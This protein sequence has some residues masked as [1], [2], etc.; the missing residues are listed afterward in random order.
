MNL[1]N[2]DSQA[3]VQNFWSY[4]GPFYDGITP[5]QK[6]TIEKFW[7]ALA[8]GVQS[9]AI[10]SLEAY[11]SSNLNFT[12]GYIEDRFINLKIDRREC[13][14]IPHSP[15]V[16]EILHNDTLTDTYREIFITGV[17]I[18]DGVEVQTTP[19][20]AAIVYTSDPYQ[21]SWELLPGIV[22]Y[23]VYTK[24]SDNSSITYS[25]NGD[26]NVIDNFDSLV[27]VTG[28]IYP[29]KNS[30]ILKY[31]YNLGND[32][33]FITIPTLVTKYSGLTLV[34]GVDYDIVNLKELHINFGIELYDEYYANAIIKVAPVLKSLYLQ[35]FGEERHYVEIFKQSFYSSYVAAD[36]DIEI[37]L[38]NLVHLAKLVHAIILTLLKGCSL[39][40]LEYVVNLFYNVPFAYEAGK[41]ESIDEYDVNYNIINI[42]NILYKIP[43]TLVFAYNV[44]DNVDKYN[45]LCSNTIIADDYI[46]NLNLLTSNTNEDTLH[47]TVVLTI[48]EEITGLNYIKG[49][50]GYN[51]LDHLKTIVLNPGL[52]FKQL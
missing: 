4:L 44:G 26:K 5:A 35:I 48:P 47:N 22:K 39:K 2:I 36:S 51:L 13:L 10:N 14:T 45:L 46:S 24:L 9:L 42:S 19:S 16:L 18:I 43:K 23:Y 33:Y 25:V 29:S 40:R 31:V 34:E 15:P 38:N 12:K 27:Q 41:V 3:E 28:I 7:K 52:V 50:T 6:V 37:K 49:I 32:D 20:E 11:Y 1:V 8:D 17:Q 21:V 30:T